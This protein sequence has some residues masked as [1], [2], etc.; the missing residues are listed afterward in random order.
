MDKVQKNSGS[1]RPRREIE[2]VSE[3]SDDDDSDCLSGML[4]GNGE[5][6]VEQQSTVVSV[7]SLEEQN[8]PESTQHDETDE[9][10]DKKDI[11]KKKK[12]NKQQK[13]ENPE[14]QILAAPGMLPGGIAIFCKR[15]VLNCRL[16][17]G[18]IPPQPTTVFKKRLNV[19]NSNPPRS[20]SIEKEA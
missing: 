4:E 2:T 17:I 19:I 11:V 14:D 18:W 1:K 8:T 10:C 7:M 3:D 15:V 16:N 20:N 5:G 9:K 6:E 13:V 12:K